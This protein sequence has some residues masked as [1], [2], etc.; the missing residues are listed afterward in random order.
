MSK[1]RY[2]HKTSVPGTDSEYYLSRLFLMLRN[3][4]GSNRPDLVTPDGLYSPRFSLESK[5]GKGRKVVLNEDQFQYAFTAQSD[6]EYGWRDPLFRDQFVD[7]EKRIMDHISSYGKEKI[8]FPIPLYYVAIAR[9]D[10]LKA[11]DLDTPFA[12]I[13]FNWGDIYLLPSEMVFHLFATNRAGRE[14]G[15]KAKL[16]DVHKI[17]EGMRETIKAQI[18]GEYYYREA[19]SNSNFWQS[20]SLRALDAIFK[21][22]DTVTYKEK[23]KMKYDL[24][25][26]SFPRLETLKRIKLPGPKGTNIFIFAEKSE[27]DLF[28]K[29]IRST[30]EQRVP[31]LN[32]VIT[33]REEY[34]LLLN[35]IKLG[36]REGMFQTRITSEVPSLFRAKILEDIT[37]EQMENLNRLTRWLGKEETSIEDQFNIFKSMNEN[38]GEGFLPEEL[39]KHPFQE[40]NADIP[41]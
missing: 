14:K 19:R 32:E 12:S 33:E 38:S 37:Q 35:Q 29:Q 13:K 30:V 11:E 39:P 3:F 23:G 28:D 5:S 22:D 9:D 31:V 21:E 16:A 4:N 41:F 18:S 7:E 26:E 2:K 25:H 15:L 24:L 10:K 6:Y 36:Y 40:E 27:Q 8:D 17:E 1:L 20:L 34:R